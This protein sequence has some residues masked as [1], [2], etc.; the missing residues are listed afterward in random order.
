MFHV[1]RLDRT[2]AAAGRC[3]TWNLSIVSESQSTLIRP[4]LSLLHSIAAAGG[5]KVRKLGKLL[6]EGRHD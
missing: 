6:V 4:N 2:R 3:F 5:S 1:G